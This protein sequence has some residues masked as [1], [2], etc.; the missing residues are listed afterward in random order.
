V[1]R[2]SNASSED[3]DEILSFL[4]SRGLVENAYLIGDVWYELNGPQDWRSIIVCRARRGLSGVAS[5]SWTDSPSRERWGYDYVALMDAAEREAVAALSRTLPA[6]RTGSI[7]LFTSLTQEYFDGLPDAERREGDL[8]F[9]VS[10][11]RFQ[12]VAGDPVI[13]VTAADL[14]LYEGCDRQPSREDWEH[15][16]EESRRM[17]ILRNGR[18]AT[19]AGLAPR[20]PKGATRRRVMCISGLYT[21][22]RHRRMGLGR[23]LVSYLTELILRD[24]NVPEYWTEPDNVASRNLATSLGYRQ[25]AQK[26]DYLWRRPAR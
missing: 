15:R 11:E 23:R 6:D 2:T 21:Q 9:T 3:R 18:V 10:A 19:S 22:T 14:H 13:E 24:G 5:I 7:E 20:T 1:Y 16:D 4:E 26:V 12:P 8:Y 17:A 25:Y